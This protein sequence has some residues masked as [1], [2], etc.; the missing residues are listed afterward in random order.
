MKT[1]FKLAQAVVLAGLILP[2]LVAAQSQP[3]K[4]AYDQY[5]KPQSSGPVQTWTDKVKQN[6]SNDPKAKNFD[7][8]C[9][10]NR[11]NVK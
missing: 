10:L 4:P 7:P 3:V 8:Y 5:A 11:A 2:G 9:D 6:C 1:F